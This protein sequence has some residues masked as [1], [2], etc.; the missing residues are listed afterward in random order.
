MAHLSKFVEKSRQELRGLWD[1]CYFGQ[2][3][4]NAFRAMC[5]TDYNEE[6]L[7]EHENEV[8][9]LKGFLKE[10]SEIFEKVYNESHYDC[11][12]PNL[13]E[14]QPQW[15]ILT[16]NIFLQVNVWQSWWD[17]KKALQ[18]RAK[19]PN[20]LFARRGNTLLKEQQEEKEVKRNLPKVE[21]ELRGMVQEYDNRH[22]KI[23]KIK[24]KYRVSI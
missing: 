17:R 3:Q 11:P 12:F 13:E 14:I 23:W 21:R 5:S 7:D 18:D 2:E 4:R 8:E 6:M 10:N 19:D 22:G 20:R 9:R 15:P 24:Q 1:Q 16:Y